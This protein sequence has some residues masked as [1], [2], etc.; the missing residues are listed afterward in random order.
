M[1]PRHRGK[2]DAQ[3][4][5]NRY[6]DEHFPTEVKPR[7]NGDANNDCA[8]S[9]GRDV[10]SRSA[11]GPLKRVSYLAPRQHPPLLNFT[12]R[13]ASEIIGFGGPLR[14]SDLLN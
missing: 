1:R 4:N 2:H 8:P 12:Y 14:K 3:Q 10:S 7:D 9:Y 6:W 5:S 13:G 11:R